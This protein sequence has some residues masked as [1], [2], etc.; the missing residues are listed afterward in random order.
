MNDTARPSNRKPQPPTDASS[1]DARS[2]RSRKSATLRVG[3]VLEYRVARLFIWSDFFVRRG[4]EIY[5]VAVLDRATDLD[6]LAI[7][8]TQPF[9]R[10]VQI[11]ECKSD[12]DR[13]LDRIFWLSGVK[14]FV[15]AQTATL[16]RRST[17]WNIKDFAK[18]AGVEVLDLPRL[19]ELEKDTGVDTS[20]W[21]GVSDREFFL[22]FEEEWNRALHRDE[23]LTELCLTLASEVRYQDPFGGINYLLHNTRALTR[24]LKEQRLSSTSLG[25]FLLCDSISHLAMFLMRIAES[26]F[27]LSDADRSGLIRKGLTYGHMDPKLTDRIFRNAYRIATE[28]LKHYGRSDVKLDESFF[29]MPTPPNVSEIQEAIELLIHHPRASASFAPIADLLLF[30]VYLKG[31][32]PDWLTRIYPYSD[33][34]ERLRLVQQFVQILVRIGAGPDDLEAVLFLPEKKTK[35]EAVPGQSTPLKNDNQS[36]ATTAKQD[37]PHPSLFSSDSQSDQKKDKQ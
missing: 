21:P 37:G 27:G 7:R 15:D 16:I 3:D 31:R 24:A 12:G 33:L 19:E 22:K 13:P 10:D 32:N 11:A 25:K 29:K 34:H 6:V 5:T 30:E 8:Y 18:A 4:R 26:S 14:Q 36:A 17:K 28:T 35:G 2:E 23:V 9:H 1:D 20:I